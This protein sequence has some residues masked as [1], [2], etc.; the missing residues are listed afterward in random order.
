MTIN[1]KRVKEALEKTGGLIAPAAKLLDMTRSGLY[2]RLSKDEKLQEARKEAT[3]I[4]ADM[5]EYKLIQGIQ[6]GQPW[7]VLFYLKTRCKDR[8][9][10]EKT[11]TQIT[12]SVEVKV[13][14]EDILKRIE[15]M[16]QEDA[17]RHTVT[18]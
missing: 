16:E 5:A 17:K 7:A 18:N 15:K 1:R 3:E 13:T 11:E 8:G 14:K 12:G 10:T 2:K 6:A 9:Y 4:V